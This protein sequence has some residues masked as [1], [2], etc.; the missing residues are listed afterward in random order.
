LLILDHYNEALTGP[1]K[2]AKADGISRRLGGV[3]GKVFN[4][5]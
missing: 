5:Q 3:L 2:I 4:Q 1:A